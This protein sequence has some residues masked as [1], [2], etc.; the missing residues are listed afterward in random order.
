[1]PDA[2][3]PAAPQ[4]VPA[5]SGET[6]WKATSWAKDLGARLKQVGGDAGGGSSLKALLGQ[7]ASRNVRR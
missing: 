2:A 3:L 6:A 4:H 5:E 7:V 1:M